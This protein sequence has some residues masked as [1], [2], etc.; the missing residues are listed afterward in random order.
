MVKINLLPPDLGPNAAVLKLLNL[1]KKVAVIISITFFII[2][3]SLTGYILLLRTELQASVKRL[4]GLKNSIESLKS[5]EQ[6]LYLLKERVGNIK[7]LLI[8]ETQ[9]EPLV[10][11]ENLLLD[12]PGINLTKTSTSQGKFIISGSSQN[13]NDLSSFFESIITDDNYKSI[14][15]DSLIFNPK[16]GYI[17]SLELNLK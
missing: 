8:K 2:G 7:K 13:T 10:S 5:T 17:F 3:T 16:A 14:K 9:L 1:V 6:S 15:L 4:T 12:H 11:S